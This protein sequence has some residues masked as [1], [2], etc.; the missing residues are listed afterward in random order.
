MGAGG[1]REPSLNINTDKSSE[2]CQREISGISQSLRAY[3]H[4]FNVSVVKMSKLS[5]VVEQR[6]DHSSMFSNLRESEAIE[7]DVDICYVHLL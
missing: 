1:I 4:E 5:R 3:T 7:Q 2:L 6:L